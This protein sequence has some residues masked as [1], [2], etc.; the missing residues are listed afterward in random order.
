MFININNP[1][2][3]IRILNVDRFSTAYYYRLRT[4]ILS[5]MIIENLREGNSRLVRYTMHV[6]S[7]C[8]PMFQHIIILYTWCTCAVHNQ[9]TY[10]SISNIVFMQPCWYYVQSFVNESGRCAR[11]GAYLP[12]S[13]QLISY[14]LPVLQRTRYFFYSMND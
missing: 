8:S 7:R 9:S 11:T 10:L 14:E 5:S 12:L 6:H 2:V 13:M 3:S 1:N 4:R